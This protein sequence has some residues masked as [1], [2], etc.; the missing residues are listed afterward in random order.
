MLFAPVVRSAPHAPV[1]RDLTARLHSNELSP[2]SLSN[3]IP[4]ALSHSSFPC[5]ALTSFFVVLSLSSI[6]HTIM[7]ANKPTMTGVWSNIEPFVLGGAS[8]MFATVCIQPMD[9]VKVRIQLAGEGQKGK[10][11]SPFTIGRDIVAKEGF[12]ALYRGLSAGL[13]R[14]ATYT[15]TRLG[16]FRSIMDNLE[17]ESGKSSFATKAIAGLSAG[18]IGSIVGTPADLALIRMQADSTLPVDQRR[19]YTGVVNAL[20]RITKEEGF[21]GL[22][23]GCAPVVVRAMALNVGMLSC[24][25]Q[26]QAEFRKITDNYWLQNIGAKGVS[27]FCAAACSL[28]FDFV[29]TRIQ[30]QKRGP[31]GEFPYKNMADCVKKVMKNEG[32]MAFY[33]G[34]GTYCMRIAPHVIITLFAFDGMKAMCDK[35]LR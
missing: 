7:S 18:G 27:G 21:F 9:M 3:S 5:T 2:A 17:K 14:Q 22:F 29:K 15:T 16:I 24:H 11:A 19:N 10:G 26:A 31:D 8:G 35:Y 32:P 1:A 4:P 25:D 12:G 33:R 28:P 20:A 13:L 6:Y 23:K 30:K 34:F